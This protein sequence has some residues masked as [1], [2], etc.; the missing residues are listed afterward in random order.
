LDICAS[1][2]TGIDDLADFFPGQNQVLSRLV[3]DKKMKKI[4][5]EAKMLKMHFLATEDINQSDMP[6]A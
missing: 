4:V 6:D 3:D 2:G 1:F 5:F